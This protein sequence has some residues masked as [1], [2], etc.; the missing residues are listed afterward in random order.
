MRNLIL[1]GA[2]A[3]AFTA[4]PLMAQDMADDMDSDMEGGAYNMNPTQQQKFMSWEDEQRMAYEG[5]P[6]NA[7]EYYWTLNQDQMR[8]WWVLNDEQRLRIVAMQ[9]QQRAAAWTSIMNQM[10]GATPMPAT[11]NA[12]NAAATPASRMA[13][14]SGM[15]NTMSGNIQYRSTERVQATPGDQGPPTGEMPVCSANQQDNCIN[16]WEAGKRGAGVNRPLDSWPGRPASE[17]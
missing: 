8:G 16:A 5:W 2:A 10:S 4:S 11:Q 3:L 13:S 6:A 7:Q 15:A 17:M 1:A 9:P 14:P 12:A